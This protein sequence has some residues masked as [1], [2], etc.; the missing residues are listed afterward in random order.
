[1][2]NISIFK[3]LFCSSKSVGGAMGA[4]GSSDPSTTLVH[5]WVEIGYWAFGACPVAENRN[6]NP[7]SF[8][9]LKKHLVHGWDVKR[10][11]TVV[12][13]VTTCTSLK[14]GTQTNS[15]A[16][17]STHKT[18]KENI[19]SWEQTYPI[20]KALLSR[21]CSFFQGWDMDSFCGELDDSPIGRWR[22]WEGPHILREGSFSHRYLYITWIDPPQP[23]M[24]S[25]PPGWHYTFSFGNP[26]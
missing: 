20:S 19:P 11:K 18:F 25:S 21:W 4:S 23:R 8:V 17:N 16:H 14:T 22:S 6:D 3:N 9:R 12:G 15:W 2:G 26:T 13:E 1:M 10:K 5:P 7:A 24:Q